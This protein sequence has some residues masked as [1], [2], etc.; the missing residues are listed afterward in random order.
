MCSVGGER[1]GEGGLLCRLPFFLFFL[2]LPDF[3]GRVEKRR[4][5][6]DIYMFS[7]EHRVNINTRHPLLLFYFIHMRV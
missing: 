1:R 2:S 4:P 6:S 7:L 3:S 5:Y